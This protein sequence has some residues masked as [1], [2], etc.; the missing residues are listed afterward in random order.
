MKTKILITLLLSPIFLQAQKYDIISNQEEFYEHVFDNFQLNK[1]STNFL[2]EQGHPFARIDYYNGN[3]SVLNT[4]DE[5]AL[6][7][8]YATLYNMQIKEKN[9]LKH[10]SKIEK[11]LNK[12]S[13]GQ[14]KLSIIGYAFQYNRLPENALSSGDVVLK[15]KKLVNKSRKKSDTF[16]QEKSMFAM[17]LLGKQN[18]KQT[19]TF[20]FDQ[21]LFFSGN[22]F[23]NKQ[24]KV[25]FGDGSGLM[26]LVP[27]SYYTV[28][29]GVKDSV[30]IIFDIDGLKSHTPYLSIEKNQLN[31]TIKAGGD[32]T[33][34]I[35]ANIKHSAASSYAEGTLT[36]DYGEFSNEKLDKPILIVEGFDETDYV[37]PATLWI[38]E[39]DKPKDYNSFLERKLDVVPIF[40]DNLESNGYDIVHLNFDKS[41]DY[42]Q[43]SAY[44]VQEAIRK[45]K[46]HPDRE[47]D[48]VVI[49][50]SSGGVIAKYAL[51]DWENRFTED[52][53]VRLNVAFDTGF[54]GNNVPVGM[55]YMIGHLNDMRISGV[56]LNFLFPTLLDVKKLIET[57]AAL[58]M[59]S[60]SYKNSLSL[61]QSFFNELNNLGYPKLCR[62]IS[63]SNGDRLDN[64]PTLTPNEF[65]I[66]KDRGVFEIVIP[67]VT[68]GI[69][70][71]I[72]SMGVFARTKIQIKSL[73]SNNQLTNVYE[74]KYLSVNPF[75]F[76]YLISGQDK[77]HAGKASYSTAAGGL[78]FDPNGTWTS[79]LR[80]VTFVPT[81][82]ALD[83][84]NHNN[85]QIYQN[86]YSPSY[87]ICE[88][89]FDS[90]YTAPS[91][92]AHVEWNDGNSNYLWN[93]IQN[94]L[95]PCQEKMCDDALIS[96]SANLCSSGTY[97]INNRPA[98]SSITW[99]TSGNVSISSGRY[100]GT[101][102]VT[103]AGSG[104]GYI[105]ARISKSGCGIAR[106]RKNI[107]VGKPSST[108]FNVSGQSNIGQYQTGYYNIR[109]ANGATSHRIEVLKRKA[110]CGPGLVLCYDVV[111]TGTF[112]VSYN[113]T[114][115][116]NY[117]VR[118]KASNSCGDI[119]S[120]LGV[121]VGEPGGGGSCQYSMQL[122]SDNPS[123][124]LFKY[125]LINPIPIEPCHAELKSNER[126]TFQNEVVVRNYLGHVILSEKLNADNF[127][128]DLSTEP[129]GVYMI[130]VRYNG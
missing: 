3:L 130:D 73:H 33:E 39:R 43:N 113:F 42:M 40:R 121:N 63:I 46:A 47:D 54:D 32:F 25:D 20:Y 89:P 36:Y 122:T 35:T 10:H 126:L 108:G 84:M 12:A 7:K 96:G 55:Q 128:F 123:Y 27:N 8:I 118:G 24:L 13:K 38:R 17:G 117:L 50:L 65:I 15:N 86:I 105:E 67:G 59:L 1:L 41:T 72:P 85:P 52:H 9:Q 37:N 5:T 79:Y 4:V 99:Y 18:L 68:E 45:L 74:G 61:H 30:K 66:N 48:I 77:N 87:N 102:T 29:Y 110:S 78:F 21:N 22:H 90:W 106:I 127:E 58:Q 19:Q 129:S 53:E 112:S 125:R 94:N 92:E 107:K 114:Q 109:R 64:R 28:N 81:A 88:T 83:V 11:I 98:S 95:A 34:R 76:L 93:E 31:R 57:P 100:T 97:T 80:Q 101:V 103:G 26:E 111:A 75:L 115:Q 6:R 104:S 91:N 44:L 23:K 69:L 116:G 70:I 51:A 82:S 49:G 2:L 62:N 14:D 124:D 119:F 60:V 16:F 71:P 56:N 120:T